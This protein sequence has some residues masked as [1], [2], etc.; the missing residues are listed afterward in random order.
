MHQCDLAF[1]C[2]IAELLSIKF[3]VI[4]GSG[5]AHIFLFFGLLF[6]EVPVAGRCLVGDGFFCLKEPRPSA[7][8][9]NEQ[10]GIGKYVPRYSL[11]RSSIHHATTAELL[12]SEAPRD[13]A[14]LLYLIRQFTRWFNIP[15]TFR[16]LVPCEA[17]KFHSSAHAIE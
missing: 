9:S 8:L 1:K 13:T 17:E 6:F 11:G 4:T 3:S 12:R 16:P 5:G 14:E 2:V 15:C 10:R 7:P